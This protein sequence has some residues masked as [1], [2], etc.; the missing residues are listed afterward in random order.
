MR[1]D[2]CP[3]SAGVEKGADLE[4]FDDE[5]RVDRVLDK[6]KVAAGDANAES[7]GS[8]PE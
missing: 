6:G 2:D 1:L 4:F 8:L 7:L 3:R 5:R